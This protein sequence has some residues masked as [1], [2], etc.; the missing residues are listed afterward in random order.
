[1]S[2][3]RG[4]SLF[5]VLLMYFICIKVYQHACRLMTKL[6]RNEIYGWSDTSRP[7]G[8]ANQKQAMDLIVEITKII[9]PIIYYPF[10]LF[11]MLLL[12]RNSLFEGWVLNWPLVLLFAGFIVYIFFQAANFQMRASSARNR[13]LERLKKQ[14]INRLG[15]SYKHPGNIVV[16]STSNST[17]ASLAASDKEY[18]GLLDYTIEEIKGMNSGAFVHWTSHPLFKAVALPSS[19][20]GILAVLLQ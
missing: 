5:S 3:V 10:F 9:T 18:D 13:I 19:S 8:I 4:L 12:S 6:S 11:T 17:P 2:V 1:V 14:K 7:P 16:L 15:N 20:L